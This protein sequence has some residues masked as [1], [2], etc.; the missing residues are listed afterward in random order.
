M[1]DRVLIC[2]LAL[3]ASACLIGCG[4]PH[5][6]VSGKVTVNGQVLKKSGGRI[7]FYGPDGIGV[8]ATIDANGDY[9]ATGVCVGDNK[10]TVIY[11][12]APQVTKGRVPKR[13]A[14]EAKQQSESLYMTPEKYAMPETTPLSVTIAANSVYDAKL[15]D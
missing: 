2:C 1:L 10:V 14:D 8:S 3:F 6:D 9:K 11:A 7:T 13:G 15:E 12:S 4:I 5:T